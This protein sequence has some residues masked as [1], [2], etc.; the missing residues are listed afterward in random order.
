LRPCPPSVVALRL[1]RLTS[2]AGALF[3]VLAIALAVLPT[4]HAW[5]NGGGA[6]IVRERAGPYEVVVAILPEKPLV[7][8][9]HFSITPIDASTQQVV[10]NAEIVLVANDERGRPTYQSR[11]LSLPHAPRFYE[12]NILFEST[13]TWTI[14]V[15][16][17]SESLGD[18]MLTFPLEIGQQSL[19]P[20][21][22]GS[23]VFLVVFAVL[24]G[25]GGYVWYS[26]RRAARRRE[27]Q[28]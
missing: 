9:V 6:D 26:A 1:P 14:E 27:A 7:G 17:D 25:G 21:P 28:P 11:A 13:G 8:S 5:A 10:P 4:G 18:A 3:L 2:L 12:A 15:S 24:I 16:I 22:A 20:G 19:V 23:V